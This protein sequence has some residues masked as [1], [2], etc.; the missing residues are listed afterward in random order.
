[1][2]LPEKIKHRTLLVTFT[3]IIIVVAMILFYINNI[4]EKRLYEDIE[5]KDEILHNLF[6]RTLKQDTEVLEKLLEHTL[7]NPQIKEAFRK[8]DRERLYELVAPHYAEI[9][10]INPFVK[11][12][13]F[14]FEDGSAFLRVHKPQF[15]GDSLNKKREIIIDTNNKRTKHY[16]FEVGKLKMTYRIVLPIFYKNEYLGLV[17]LGIEPAG[18]IRKIADV[19][20]LKYAL[21]IKKDMKTVMLDKKDFTDRRNYTI[22][23][24]DPFFKK[25][26]KK[27]KLKQKSAENFISYKGRKYFVENDLVLNDFKGNKAAVLLAAED[28]TEEFE[29]KRELFYTFLFIFTAPLIFLF[30]ILNYSF[31]LFI[32]RIY[33]LIYKD[34]L[35]KLGNRVALKRD[36]N[37][38]KKRVLVL[39]DINS[40]KTVNELYGIEAGNEILRQFGSVLMDFAKDRGFFCYRVSSDEF[41]LVKEYEKLDPSQCKYFVK[42]LQ[43]TI[44]KHPF[45]IPET[46]SEIEIEV[47]AGI[48]YG[49]KVSLEKALMALEKAREKREDYL[50][51]S[52]SIDTKKYTQKVISMKYYIK[53][54]LQSDNILVYFQP[55]TDKNGNIIKYEALVRMIKEENGKEEVLSPYEFLEL[56]KKFNLYFE[57]SKRVLDKS[58]DTFRHRKE[59]ISI[60]LSPS[61]IIDINMQRYIVEKLES[62]PN[63]KRVVFEITESESIKDFEL[64]KEFIEKIRHTGAQIAIDD[65]GSGYSNYFHIL[66]LKPDYLKIDGSLIKEIH[67]NEESRIVV[68]TIAVFARELGVKTVAE[69]IC[70]EEIFHVTKKFGIDEFQGFYLGKP[71]PDLF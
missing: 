2:D 18:F 65:F 31:N 28:V 50:V 13:T 58:L 26:K 34:D 17:E 21:A 57:I 60:N 70:S 44:K 47:T 46:G 32:K 19:I 49:K 14:R 10:K 7:Q 54:A 1:M 42:N 22:T 36:L 16:G 39:T 30:L 63:S 29:R 52:S 20:G 64:V 6:E 27:I 38:V 68:K 71:A 53:K 48:V 40:F 67:K 8:K 45:K 66:E 35:T 37:E 33:N 41:V 11:I 4:F 9:R 5:R 56:S 3:L 25:K 24:N 12:M 51:Y 62:Y 61:D 23:S 55:I 59:K 43:D 69:F 15:Y